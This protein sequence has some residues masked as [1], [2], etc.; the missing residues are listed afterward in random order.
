M[1]VVVVGRLDLISDRRE[2]GM[3]R[4]GNERRDAG[5][6]DYQGREGNDTGTDNMGNL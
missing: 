6:V 5:E 3:R 1:C 4:G 2:E